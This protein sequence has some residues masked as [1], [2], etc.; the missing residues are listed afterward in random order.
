MSERPKK[1]GTCELVKLIAL[2]THSDGNEKKKMIV[3]KQQYH[4]HWNEVVS[5]GFVLVGV[6]T[7]DLQQAKNTICR[8]Q[9]VHVSPINNHQDI[10]IICKHMNRKTS[11][12]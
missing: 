7:S 12:K 9:L 11:L 3:D 4:R 8:C 6:D 2:P 10:I 1:G 5:I